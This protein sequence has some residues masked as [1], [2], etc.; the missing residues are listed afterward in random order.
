MF[1]SFLSSL[2]HKSFSFNNKLLLSC[3]PCFLLSFADFFFFQPNF[4]SA[5]GTINTCQ[6]LNLRRLVQVSE[7]INQPCLK[8]FP[9]SIDGIWLD[10]SACHESR[11]SLL[12]NQ[13]KHIDA[14]QKVMRLW[15]IYDDFR[16]CVG[17]IG[18]V[19]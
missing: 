14:F 16:R 12:G 17:K 2:D 6:L 3:K 10:A 19:G 8:V 5:K 1:H 9:V 13:S 4:S 18:K 7:G 15:V 11:S